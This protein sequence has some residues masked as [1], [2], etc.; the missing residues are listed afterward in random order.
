MGSAKIWWTHALCFL[1]ILTYRMFAVY[2]FCFLFS[3]WEWGALPQLNWEAPTGFFCQEVSS[4][5]WRC[6][7]FWRK[8]YLSW[9]AAAGS[10]AKMGWVGWICSWV[11]WEVQNGTTLGGVSMWKLQV[12]YIYIYMYMIQHVAMQRNIGCM[13]CVILKSLSFLAGLLLVWSM[14][15]DFDV[16]LYHRSLLAAVNQVRVTCLRRK[17]L[18]PQNKNILTP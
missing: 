3:L 9:A 8:F 15:V 11:D 7:G 12:W 13:C 1:L 17:M 14:D 16:P 4:V 5:P 2:D 18:H 10:L 6:V